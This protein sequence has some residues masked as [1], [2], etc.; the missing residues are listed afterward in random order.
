MSKFTKKSLAVLTTAAIMASTASVVAYAEQTAAYTLTN[1][2]GLSVK[3]YGSAVNDASQIAGAWATLKTETSAAAGFSTEYYN[4]VYAFNETTDDIVAVFGTTEV[5]VTAGAYAYIGEMTAD[6]TLSKKTTAGPS[7]PTEPGKENTD[8]VVWVN[9]KDTKANAKTGTPASLY[10]SENYEQV[11]MSA[12]GKWQVAVTPATV[13]TVEDFMKEFDDKGKITKAK[14]Y[15]NLASAKVKEGTVTVT[16]GKEGGEINVWVYEVKAKAVVNTEDVKPVATKFTVKVA[17]TMVVTATPV[18]VTDGA[19]PAIAK[20]DKLEK[21]Y[22]PGSEVLAYF[23]DKKAATSLDATFVLM[24]G[25]NPAELKDGKFVGDGFT[26]ELVAAG[27]N[28][29]AVKIVIA[30]DAK[31]K[32]K[33]AVSVKNVESAKVAKISTTVGKAAETPTP[34]PGGEEGGETPTPAPEA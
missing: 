2:S 9:G 18:K 24:D 30:A 29:P 20:A 23:G 33:I 3:Y 21:S 31:E 26:A 27:E 7:T 12:G 22:A 34:T 14:D 32:T 25:K 17:P 11:M 10:K 28:G 16:A 19:V 1:T 15:K 13:A 5:T 4:H 8:K 6:T